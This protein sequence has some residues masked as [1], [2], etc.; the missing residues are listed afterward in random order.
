MPEGQARRRLGVGRVGESLDA[1]CA[2]STAPAT[3]I[4]RLQM[5]GIH[6]NRANFEIA[7]CFLSLK[8]IRKFSR[9]LKYGRKTFT[10]PHLR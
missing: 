5:P 10:Y 7:R 8:P 6:L 1:T 9:E 4:H 2:P 3:T